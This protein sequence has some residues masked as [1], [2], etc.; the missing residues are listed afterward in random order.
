MKAQKRKA[1]T[2]EGRHAIAASTTNVTDGASSRIGL[3]VTLAVALLY[4]A[5]IGFHWLPLDLS[6]KELA[7]SASRV[8]DIRREIIEQHHIP[9]WTPYYMSGSSY[10]LNHARGLYLVPWL[11]FS[12]FTD[13]I[14]AGKLVALSAIFASAVGMYFCARY[15][16]R[17]EW[18]AVL[19]AAVF[20][21]HPEQLIRATGAEH[22]TISLSFVFIPLLWLSLAR[23]LESNAFRDIFLCAL[24]AALAWWADN[25]QAFVNFL[26]SSGYVVCWSWQQ[27]RHW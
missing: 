26:F 3:W 11:L 9:W 12:T 13:L 23:A 15:F 22:I 27:R 2:I 1:T 7:A 4:C 24:V 6:D 8:W 16:L 18:A 10:G 5:W 20:L 25:K 19:S 21:L 17:N 14:T